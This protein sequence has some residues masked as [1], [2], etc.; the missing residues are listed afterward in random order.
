MGTWANYDA[1][2]GVVAATLTARGS[3][4]FA[5]LGSV[6]AE[7][8]Q[9]V[10]DQ[11]TTTLTGP[12][13][14]NTLTVS[15]TAAGQ[16]LALGANG[17]TTAGIALSGNRDFT[18]TSAGGT[19]FG[20]SPATAQRTI[21]V[22]DPN[23]ALITSASLTGSSAQAALNK[24]GPGFLILNGAA[25]QVNFTAATRVN[26]TDGVLRAVL[27]GATP[28]FG[29]NGLISFR[30]GVL[31]VDSTGISGGTTFT[32]ALGNAAG[33]VN[34][35]ATTTAGTTFADNGSGGF[36]AVGGPLTVA[37]GGTATPTAITWADSN[38]AGATAFFLIG[39][40]SLLFG[41]ARSDSTVVWQN[42][43]GLDN[44]T[45][46]AYALREIRVTRGTGGPND[47]TQI[48]SVISGSAATDLIKS[49]N[50]VLELTANNTYGGSTLVVNTGTLLV[51][52][53]STGSATGTGKVTVAA[54]ATLG[55]AGF[56]VPNNGSTASNA[57]TI[58]G[59]VSP[60]N[61]IG[62][63]TLGSAATPASVFLNGTYLAEIGTGSDLL[64]VNGP[65]TL[66]PASRLMVIGTP[67]GQPYTLATYS[68]LSG[69]FGSTNLPTG[70]NVFYGPTSITVS[71]VPEPAHVLLV[72]GGAAG[73]VGWWRRRKG[74]RAALV[75]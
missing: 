14:V 36:S 53:P 23:A 32:R 49:G 34:W 21:A 39:A 54:G 8:T 35:R 38:N 15:P 2:N 25:D 43:L 17:L 59:T 42:P 56:I 55:G 69:T 6:P 30:G 73:V 1:T 66:G 45:A 47:K 46:G 52:N 28:N 31:E 9:F 27:G 7:N 33:N 37:I 12:V 11:P 58:N 18:I 70:Y 67:S 44:G 20:A 48:T 3:A 57:V 41:S 4:A 63:L 74:A 10:P 71:P 16:A 65:L 29:P 40:N 64:A 26:I 62:T 22:L 50:G 68:A 5:G 51:N 24:A 13:T 72:C 60:G 61:G 19:L 75:A